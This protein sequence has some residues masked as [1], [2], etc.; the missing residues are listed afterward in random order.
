LFNRGNPL[1]IC[2]LTALLVFFTLGCPNGDEDVRVEDITFS[3]DIFSGEKGVYKNSKDNIADRITFTNLATERSGEIDV[4][5]CLLYE[6]GYRIYRV[7]DDTIEFDGY[8][9]NHIYPNFQIPERY[10]DIFD[11]E[12]EIACEYLMYEITIQD[13]DNNRRREYKKVSVDYNHTEKRKQETNVWCGN[14]CAQMLDITQEKVPQENFDF[15][16]LLQY[17]QEINKQISGN[18]NKLNPYSEKRLSYVED[19][20]NTFSQYRIIFYQ[21]I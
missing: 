10:F 13:Q 18:T 5:V 7:F 6:G 19:G 9:I 8:E 2:I 15:G 17:R 1:L 20:I 11:E 14:A 21:R 16:L 12:N 3:S 4:E